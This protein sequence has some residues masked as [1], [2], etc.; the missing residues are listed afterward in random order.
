MHPGAPKAPIISAQ[1]NG[2]GTR[3]AD[4]KALKAR[5]IGLAI[6]AWQ[7]AERESFQS[8][9]AEI[10]PRRWRLGVIG[11]LD[12]ERCSRLVWA[13]PLARLTA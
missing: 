3:V 9:S 13:G 4:D 10:G 8:S 6:E 2:L 5:F 11:T 1:P 12:L 7:V